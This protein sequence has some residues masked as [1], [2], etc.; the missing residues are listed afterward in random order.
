M[1]YFSQG[2]DLVQISS[3]ASKSGNKLAKNICKILFESKPA[4]RN[5]LFI[6]GRMAYLIDMDEEEVDVPSTLL[7]SVCETNMD[8]TNENI[9]ADNLLIN[10]RMYIAL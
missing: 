2:E 8:Q 6:R 4:Q 9:N 7:R 3:D 5:D 1:D 10:V